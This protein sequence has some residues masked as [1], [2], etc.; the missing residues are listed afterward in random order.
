MGIT[1]LLCFGFFLFPYM[2]GTFIFSTV[3]P[4]NALLMWFYIFF[5]VYSQLV[6]KMRI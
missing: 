2:Y 3:N 4:R 6:K 5:G 1:I